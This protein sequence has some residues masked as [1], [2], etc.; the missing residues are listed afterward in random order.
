[1][2]AFVRS[3]LDR[4]A[5]LR[6]RTGW[7]P[8]ILDIGGSLACPT[9][10][11]I[12]PRQFRLNRALGVD[13]LPPDPGDCL[14]IADAAR[15]AAALVRDDAAA[16]GVEAPRVVLEPGRALTADTQF[17]LTSVVDVNDGALPHAILDAG[18][19]LAEPVTSE[20]HQLVSVT[21]PGLPATTAYRL[22]G[23]ICTPADVLYQ[24]WRLPPL[25]PG[26]VL[27]IMDSG[28]YF[29]PFSTTFSFPKPAIVIQDGPDVTV[30][31][32]AETYDD[33][34]GLDHPSV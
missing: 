34:I 18:V 25:A 14:R 17:L 29:V 8:A 13:L 9:T 20:Y 4:A 12:P 32:R 33:I 21:S 16:R 3:V 11:G 22:A 26:H 28:A 30:A 31:R 6:E 2:T 27:A 7:S 1:M 23:P 5:Q 15:I 10:S 24:H 19:N